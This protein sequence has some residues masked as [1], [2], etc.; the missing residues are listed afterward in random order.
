MKLKNVKLYEEF[1]NENSREKDLLDYDIRKSK[2]PVDIAQDN[3][4]QDCR[5]ELVIQG[6]TNPTEGEVTK[7]Y[8]KR[9]KKEIES[10]IE[11][12]K[13]QLKESAEEE[14]ELFNE[15]IGETYDSKFISDYI[16]EISEGPETDIPD[17]Y[18]DKIKK[19]NAVFKLETFDIEDLLRKDAS[20]KEYV[21]NGGNRY[22]D[23]E[24]QPVDDDLENPIV[25]YK[26]EVIDGYNR[27]STKYK[28]GDKTIDA[29]VSIENK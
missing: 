12:A 22:E 20:L 29:Y 14:T 28:N 25:I 9:Y 1:L 16:K 3:L 7:E 13:E 4:Y 23:S 8:D 15:N 10:Y 24:Y 19:D 21:D 18:L 6:N 17:Y 26:G 5:Q 11:K 2:N 27:T